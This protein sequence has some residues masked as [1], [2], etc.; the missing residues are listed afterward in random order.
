M[1]FPPLPNRLNVP[2]DIKTPLEQG[3]DGEVIARINQD[4]QASAEIL[5]LGAALALN[6]GQ[7]PAAEALVQR[8]FKLNPKHPD[9]QA[10]AALLDLGRGEAERGQQKRRK[11]CW[12]TPLTHRLS[13]PSY[14]QQ[15]QGRLQAPSI[16]PSKLSASRR[17]TAKLLPA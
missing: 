2:A 16:Q 3:K 6:R 7:I 5:S 17:A 11:T 13:R 14:S 1:Y 15:S 4:A 12:I 10:I 9:A 8:A